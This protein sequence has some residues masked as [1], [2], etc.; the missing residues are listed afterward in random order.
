MSALI[1]RRKRIRLSSGVPNDDDTSPNVTDS[2]PDNNASEDNATPFKEE[3][4]FELDSEQ[5]D[6][7]GLEGA[8]FHSR[9][10]F[11]KMTSNEAYCFSDV[12]LGPTQ[13]QKV[14][15]HIR[16]RLLQQ[17]LDNPKQQLLLDSALPSI[18]PPFNTDKV[19]IRR[20]YAYLERH[21]YINF[22]VFKRLKP[23]PAKKVGKAIV[24]GAGIAGLAAAQQMQQFG[25]EVIVLE[26]RDRVGGR[27][28]TFRK[29]SYV[30]DLGAMVVTGLGGNPVTVLSKQI[31]MEL[32][33]IRQKCPLYEPGKINASVSTQVPKE[34]DE[35]VER[36]FNRL[37]EATSYL[38]H[39]LDFNY[40]NGK[41]V[42]LGHA[43]EW[44]IKLQEKHVKE[45][46]TQYMKNYVALQE[47]LKTK[48][49]KLL[50]I[51][52]NLKE[53]DAQK[54]EYAQEKHNN[55]SSSF[56][57]R[58]VIR[59]MAINIKKWDEL[60]EQKNEIEDKLKEMEASPPSDV[61]LSTKDRQILDWHFAN[62]E[63]ANATPLNNLSLK[64]W[65]QDDDFEF[66]GKHLT[67]MYLQYIEYNFRIQ[68][69]F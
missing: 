34:K 10:P 27:I 41:P 11:D 55:A 35:M 28:A 63:F 60:I 46:L 52:E 69:I 45:K 48:H 42:S 33:R 9:L 22:G 68:K 21:G 47:R 56:G 32:H 64:H 40:C 13:T 59:E 37:L 18:E 53:L 57:Y 16:N 43:L 7:T 20:V 1:N 65:D 26:A 4:D 67:G 29:N 51:Q 31:N 49:K 17:W 39:H 50:H 3:N 23:L 62:L 24:I 19:L 66:T 38:S 54:K 44:V 8:A 2:A 5:D 15:L 61:Y 6:P 12:A 58:S 25:M 36:E 14:F 30:A